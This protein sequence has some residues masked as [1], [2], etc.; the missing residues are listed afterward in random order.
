MLTINA[1]G[2]RT[3]TDAKPLMY[4][5]QKVYVSLGETTAS[6]H[7]AGRIVAERPVDEITS[8]MTAQD[9]AYETIEAAEALVS[10]AAPESEAD[11]EALIDAL[12]GTYTSRDKVTQKKATF[13]ATEVLRRVREAKALG[14]NAEVKDA[15]VAPRWYVEINN[16]KGSAY[17]QYHFDGH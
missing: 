7:L 6:L 15:A 9:W 2:A 3:L 8:I 12:G 14:L 13:P 1:R 4:D 10:E 11:I 5:G 17:G 16:G